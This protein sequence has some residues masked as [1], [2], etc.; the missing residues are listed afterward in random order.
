[1]MA[2]CELDVTFSLMHFSLCELAL[3]VKHMFDMF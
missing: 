2:R 3:W 1:M